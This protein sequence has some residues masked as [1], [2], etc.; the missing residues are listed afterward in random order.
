MFRAILFTSLALSLSASAQTGDAARGEK[1]FREFKCIQCHAAKARQAYTPNGM[2]SAMWTHA[3]AMSKAIEA[4]R[5]PRPQMSAAQAADL[6]AY[7]GRSKD[8]DPPGDAR[9]GEK[10]YQAKLCASCHDDPIMGAPALRG[11]K[12]TASA[13]S[14]IAG[15]WMHGGGMLSRMATA[16]KQWQQ[17]S[18]E[19]IGHLVAFLNAK[20]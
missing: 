5:I 1:L 18:A 9:Q 11:R 3:T 15:L 19:E 10:L 17:I 7:F 13:Y 8:T 12:S 4:A 16:N 6:H 14:M 2:A 20:K